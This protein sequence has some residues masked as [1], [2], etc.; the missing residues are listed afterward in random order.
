MITLATCCCNSCS[1]VD[2]LK[3]VAL[4]LL[5]QLTMAVI[6]AIAILIEDAW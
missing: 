2:P 1:C 3:A 5:I 4:M 6:V